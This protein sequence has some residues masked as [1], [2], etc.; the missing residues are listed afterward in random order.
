MTQLSVECGIEG[1]NEHDRRGKGGQC[2][3][4]AERPDSL[5][6]EAVS[7]SA[8]PG[9]GTLHSPHVRAAG[10]GSGVTDE[11]DQL[12]FR[13]LAGAV[14][15]IFSAVLIVCWRDPTAGRGVGAGQD[16][17]DGASTKSTRN[18]G[19]GFS[20][21]QLPKEVQVLVRL[22]SKW[23]RCWWT[24]YPKELSAVDH[25]LR[26]CSVTRHWLWADETHHRCA[27]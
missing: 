3:E 11:W 18:G 5:V 25:S 9:L 22:P 17:F 4:G 8:G 10:W 2:G 6:D 15:K 13:N 23:M 7:R 16:A 14:P 20:F 24:R 1:L 19:V 27:I 21:P 12:Q 26:P